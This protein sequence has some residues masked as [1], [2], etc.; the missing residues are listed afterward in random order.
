MKNMHYCDAHLTIDF[1]RKVASLDSV[2][3]ILTKKDYDLLVLLVQ[4]AGVVVPR[5]ELLM[6]VWGY[7]HEIRTRTLDVH[8]RHLRKRLGRYATQYIETV[9]GIGHRFQP[10][11]EALALTA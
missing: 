9:F 6:S 5:S 8:I 3:M 11:H 2:P 4:N 7:N 1:Q 10:C